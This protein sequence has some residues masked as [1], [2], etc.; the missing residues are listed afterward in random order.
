MM[1]GVRPRPVASPVEP[2]LAVLHPVRAAGFPEPEA[3]P[4]GVLG[5]AVPLTSPAGP[6]AIAVPPG[7][8]RWLGT[9]PPDGPGAR[10]TPPGP[11]EPLLSVDPAGPDPLLVPGETAEGAEAPGAAVPTPP[12]PPA[13]PPAPPPLP[14]PPV[15]AAARMVVEVRK[16]AVKAARIVELADIG[17][18]LRMP[19]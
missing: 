8:T 13:A 9:L 7:P 2:D 1:L 16:A 5:T 15:C 11:T 12:V 17:S 6:G 4:C 18:S 19:F 3:A 14:P 10:G